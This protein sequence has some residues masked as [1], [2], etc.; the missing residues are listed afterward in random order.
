MF[1]RRDKIAEREQ[2]ASEGAISDDPYHRIVD[3]PALFDQCLAQ[4]DCA[5]MKAPHPVMSPQT[6]NRL[7]LLMRLANLRAQGGRTLE[8]FARFVSGISLHRD[9]TESEG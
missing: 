5:I 6:K 4:L 8:R 9:E 7:Y 2:G 3:I 1:A